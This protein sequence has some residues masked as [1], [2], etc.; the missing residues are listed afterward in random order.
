L[1]R[2]KRGIRSIRPVSDLKRK[3]KKGEATSHPRERKRGRFLVRKKKKGERN[4]HV[5]S[6]RK[7]GVR[8]KKKSV[9]EA[10]E[11]KKKKERR[12][13]EPPLTTAA[14]GKNGS[15]KKK[16]AARLMVQR[17][18]KGEEA[19]ASLFLRLDGKGQVKEGGTSDRGQYWVASRDEKRV[20]DAMA[21]SIPVSDAVRGESSALAICNKGRKKGKKEG[22]GRESFSKVTGRIGSKKEKERPAALPGPL[23]SGEGKGGG[24][25][26]F[27]QLGKD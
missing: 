14:S 4:A 25:D 18:K 20:G 19:A 6:R 17:K 10:A 24:R 23:I 8:K 13:F 12:I 11:R 21:P 26:L 15:G 1:T 2:E 5:F 9:L 27:L 7:R 22:D 16:K 3:K